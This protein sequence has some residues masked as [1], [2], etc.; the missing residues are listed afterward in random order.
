MKRIIAGMILALAV[1]VFSICVAQPNFKR[2]KKVKNGQTFMIEFE[3]QNGQPVHVKFGIQ[4]YDDQ[5]NPEVFELN[6]AGQI[7]PGQPW[8]ERAYELP[9]DSEEIIS[10][11]HVNPPC[12]RINGVLRCKQ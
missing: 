6:P 10:I 1:L 2:P 11:H 12:I 9:A 4:G 8:G 5:G 7:I 3:D